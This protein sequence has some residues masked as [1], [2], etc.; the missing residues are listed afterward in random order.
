VLQF[1]AVES[2]EELILREA[3]GLPVTSFERE[4]VARGVMMIPIP[5]AGL[6]RQVTGLDEAEATQLVE[7][8]EIT[9]PLNNQIV[10]LPA[11]DSYLGFIFARGNE[12]DSPASVEAALRRAHE[13]LHFEIEPVI[14]LQLRL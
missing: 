12:G 3:V 6:L 4:P 1:G 2:L 9:A 7:R 11:G 13:Q 14:P 10:P 5:R 8:I